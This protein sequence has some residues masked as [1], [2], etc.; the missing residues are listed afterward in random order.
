M[1]AYAREGGG[2]Q[3]QSLTTRLA[4]THRRNPNYRHGWWCRYRHR[5]EAR[6]LRATG[7]L[8]RY[9]AEAPK[10]APLAGPRDLA[11]VGLWVTPTTLYVPR[12]AWPEAATLIRL[13]RGLGRWLR[14]W[15]QHCAAGLR[16]VVLPVLAVLAAFGLPIGRAP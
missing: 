6:L 14:L 5:L 15:K 7:L 13:A 4:R 10:H 3:G 1:S 12:R 11:G 9:R 16:T 8:R 2:R